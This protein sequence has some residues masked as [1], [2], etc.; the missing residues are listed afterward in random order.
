MTNRPP[1]FTNRCCKLVSDQLSILICCDAGQGIF[2]VNPVPYLWPARMAR[3]FES[4]FRKAQDATQNRLHLLAATDQLKGFVLA[5]RG[6][7]DERVPYAPADRVRREE[8]FEYP[9]DFG[10]MRDE[11]TLFHE[12]RWALRLDSGRL[13]LAYYNPSGNFPLSWRRF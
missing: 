11:D 3:A 2:Q 4:V 13:V 5:Y 10:A 6:Q 9:T 7:I 1:V 8:A 12:A